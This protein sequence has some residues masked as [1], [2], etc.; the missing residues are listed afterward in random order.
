MEKIGFIANRI[1]SLAA[2]YVILSEYYDG[3]VIE[4][5]DY[6]TVSRQ[7]FQNQWR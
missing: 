1:T 6:C 4:V 5:I 7:R 2:A 3:F